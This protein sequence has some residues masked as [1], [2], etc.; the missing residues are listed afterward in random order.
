MIPIF[1]PL[2]DGQALMPEV[3]WGVLSQTLKCCIVPITS[4]GD[5]NLRESNKLNNMLRALRVSKEKYFILMDSD[6]VLGNPFM[7][8]DM[9]MDEANMNKEIILVTTHKEILPKC[10]HSPHSLMLL[11]GLMLIKFMDF[12]ESK[13]IEEA[14]DDIHRNCSVCQFIHGKED[15][16]MYLQNQK[17]HEVRRLDLTQEVVCPIQ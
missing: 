5:E 7:I 14:H 1:I 16:C 6:V 13:K 11:K 10:N 2:K 9:M 4:E 15:K 3:I 17:N 12:L 8:E